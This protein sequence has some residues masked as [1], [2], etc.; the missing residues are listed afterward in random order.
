[1]CQLRKDS[2][3]EQKLIE[4]GYEGVC[5]RCKTKFCP[6]YGYCVDDG[7]EARCVCPSSC[8][9]VS[10]LFTLIFIIID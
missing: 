5:D 1:M 8:A 2:C 6:F 9:N 4:Y 10:A 3:V 7:F